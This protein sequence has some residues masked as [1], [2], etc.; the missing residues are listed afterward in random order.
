[1]L[2]LVLVSAPACSSTPVPLD[3]PATLANART[4]ADLARLR[5]PAAALRALLVPPYRALADALATAD[6]APLAAALA[7]PGPILVR[8]HYAGDPHLTPGELHLRW[9]LPPLAEAYVVDVGGTDLDAIF[10]RDGDAWCVVPS[11]D[12]LLLPRVADPICRGY[13]RTATT[14]SR[15]VELGWLVADQAL[16]SDRDG[17]IRA[18]AL[19]AAACATTAP[20][21]TAPTGSP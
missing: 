8:R 7:R 16:R 14:A 15:C 10:V 13:L 11:L 9:A 6:L 4:P 1:V 21:T 18:C 19:A 12:P 17:E 20:P 2:V 5:L 3:L